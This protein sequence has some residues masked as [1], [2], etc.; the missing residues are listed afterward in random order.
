MKDVMLE[1]SMSE[2]VQVFI[3]R[4]FISGNVIIKNRVIE[5]PLTGLKPPCVNVC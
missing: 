1:L 3:Y 2:S 5:I 4:F